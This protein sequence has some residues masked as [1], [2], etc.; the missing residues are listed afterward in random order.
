[1]ELRGTDAVDCRLH[2]TQNPATVILI[3]LSTASYEAAQS[4]VH[5]CTKY[6]HGLALDTEHAYIRTTCLK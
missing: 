2:E 1:M 3:G 6:S 5:L 4:L